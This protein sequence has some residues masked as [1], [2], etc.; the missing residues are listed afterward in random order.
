MKAGRALLV[1][2]CVLVVAI[3]SPWWLP[4]AE[5]SRP[6][7]HGALEND[8]TAPAQAGGEA[9]SDERSATEASGRTSAADP[10]ED[11]VGDGVD[12]MVQVEWPDGR[13]AAGVEVRY[14]PPRR[15]SQRDADQLVVDRTADVEVALQATGISAT[16]DPNGRVLVHCC[17]AA[18]VCART[19]G[20]FAAK[21]AYE[22][23]E[24]LPLLLVLRPDFHVVVDVVHEDGSPRPGLEVVVTTRFFDGARA[25]EDVDRILLSPTKVPGRHRLCHAQQW[26]VLPGPRVTQWSC[27]VEPALAMPGFDARVV[28][29]AELLAGAPIP[30]V[31]PRCGGVELEFVDR[32]GAPRAASCRLVDLEDGA[33]R[34]AFGFFGPLVAVGDVRLGRRWRVELKAPTSGASPAQ[35]WVPVGE[36]VGPT[37]EGEVAKARFVVPRHALHLDATVVDSSGK[38][39]SGVHASLTALVRDG[40]ERE[41]RVVATATTHGNGVVTFEVPLAEPLVLSQPQLQLDHASLVAPW[42]SPILSDCD[43]NGD[44]GTFVVPI[45]MPVEL[46]R[47][48]YLLDGKPVTPWVHKR[49]QLVTEPGVRVPEVQWTVEGEH[50]V[51][52]GAHRSWEIV[53]SSDHSDAVVEPPRVVAR[54]SCF[55]IVLAR[56]A[57]LLVPVRSDVPDALVIAELV[58]S[59]GTARSTQPSRGSCEWNRLPVGRHE[60]RISIGGRRVVQQL[61]PH[62]APGANLWPAD[63]SPVDLRGM[64]KAVQILVRDEN[65][66]PLDSWEIARVGRDTARIGPA[67]VAHGLDARWCVR[68][69]DEARDVLVGCAG[70]VPVRMPEPTT[71]VEVV[72]AFNTAVVLRG[73]AR[74]AGAGDLELQWSVV[75]AGFADPLLAQ[76][77]QLVED[78]GSGITIGGSEAWTHELFFAPGTELLLRHRQQGAEPV[79]QRIVVG[80]VSPQAVQVH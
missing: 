40:G 11:P 16:T 58:D 47:V 59:G 13:P 54:G 36:M 19:D 71:D 70:F 73:A 45:V 75:K 46:F 66:E 60:L 61:L 7:A 80:H 49:V 31:V 76:F 18:T 77:E 29:L 32:L 12:V 72:L 43:T 41:R 74:P 17:A 57:E 23:D 22:R 9:A 78:A 25:D 30:F 79:E 69:P 1:L 52:L 2:G 14:W 26:L 10:I 62:L 4:R 38:P 5:P 3:A 50:A 39:C 33:E 15:E 34:T 35:V 48:R 27:V 28:T 37:K 6:G 51:C 53:L 24:R 67:D 68:L 65:G 20:H 44:L 56:A 8:R 63:G 55:D 42:H 21:G 64:A